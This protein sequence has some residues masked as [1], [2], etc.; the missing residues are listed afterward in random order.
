MH[1]CWQT[2]GYPAR[3]G[4]RSALSEPRRPQAQRRVRRR[5]NR[6]STETPSVRSE[7]TPRRRSV[8]RDSI[9]IE[10]ASEDRSCR[11]TILMLSLGGG[12]GNILRSL[13]AL[14]LR[15]LAFVQKS[16]PRYAERLRRA[17]V[18][19][20]LDT[21]E[22]S[23]SDV[24]AEERVIIGAQTTRRLGSRHDP[25]VARGALEESKA[26]VEALLS[27][28]SVVILVGTGGKGTG[29]G[30]IVAIAQMA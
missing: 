22:F 5:P 25:E 2:P 29:A 23:L 18:T 20:F 13:K 1:A 15:D 12:G 8:G 30:T 10:A 21:N 11:M 9:P 6:E 28:H 27:A 7:A 24:P 19:R 26:E 14:F 16:D 17:V 4:G 3:A